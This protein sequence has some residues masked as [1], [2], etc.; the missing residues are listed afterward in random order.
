MSPPRATFVYSPKIT[1]SAEYADDPVVKKL[2]A[3]QKK[4]PGQQ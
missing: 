4:K 2:L 3:L 1:V